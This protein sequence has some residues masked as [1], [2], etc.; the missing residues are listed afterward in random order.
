MDE[1]SRR[2]S[3]PDRSAPSNTS[4]DIAVVAVAV[5]KA[6]RLLMVRK[7]TGPDLI[8]PGGKRK[9]GEHDEQAVRREVAE[10]LG[11]S[12]YG[13]RSFGVFVDEA[14]HDP[15]RQVHVTVYTGELVGE[16]RPSREIAECHWVSLNRRRGLAPIHSQ[17]NP[18]LKS[19]GTERGNSITL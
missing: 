1:I 14:A 12:L 18:A 17:I 15:G 6:G 2:R 5:L 4:A 3:S 16:P 9:P 7:R 13:L 19:R 11:C 8:L 10:E